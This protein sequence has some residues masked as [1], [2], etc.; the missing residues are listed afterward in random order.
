MFQQAIK[1]LFLHSVGHTYSNLARLFL[2]LFTGV[3]FLQ[4]CIR[5]MLHFSE[6]APSLSGFMGLSAE[7][8]MALLL[9]LEL[10]C[11]AFIILGLLTRLAVLPPLVI[12]MIAEEFILAHEPATN[13]L[14]SFQPGYPVMFI[15]IFAFF[16]LAG[17]GK[18]SLDYVISAHIID[19]KEDNE[20]LEEA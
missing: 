12:M 1:Q 17:P 4:L 6:L 13:Q 18:I 10:L 19:S 9:A 7:G 5:Q 2:R 3:M 15:G 20:I 11:A 16:L 8:T 14:F